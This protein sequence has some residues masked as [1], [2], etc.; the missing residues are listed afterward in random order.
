MRQIEEASEGRD[1]WGAW[2]LGFLYLACFF[3]AFLL[4]L[5]FIAVAP[6][7]IYSLEFLVTA[8]VI[9]GLPASVAFGLIAALLRAL[10]CTKEAT[11]IIVTSLAVLGAISVVFAPTLF[12][13]PLPRLST[14]LMM[15]V[16]LALPIII[17]S[18]IASIAAY[19]IEESRDH[20][21]RR[22]SPESNR[23]LPLGDSDGWDDF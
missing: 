18:V 3:I 15:S 21:T 5:S 4:V 2:P 16:I 23:R 11:A 19:V 7:Q 22:V 9:I 13:D 8:M 10:R 12:Q 1:H 17:A 14:S 6:R 20:R